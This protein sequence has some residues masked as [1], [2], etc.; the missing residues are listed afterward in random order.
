M[1]TNSHFSRSDFSAN[2]ELPCDLLFVNTCLSFSICNLDQ[3]GEG[4]RN[5]P[6]RAVLGIKVLQWLEESKA[7]CCKDGSPRCGRTRS[8]LQAAAQGLEVVL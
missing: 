6:H 1:G 5:L 2:P 3:E 8:E 7:Q 4:W